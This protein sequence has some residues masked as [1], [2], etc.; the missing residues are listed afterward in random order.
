MEQTIRIDGGDESSLIEF[1]HDNTAPE[2][3]A[4]AITDIARICSLEI[5][6]RVILNQ[7]AGGKTSIQR[8]R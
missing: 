5:G 2:V 4:I 1:I 7:G 6:E 8:I 3:E